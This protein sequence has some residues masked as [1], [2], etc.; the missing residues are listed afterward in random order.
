MGLGK[1]KEKLREYEKEQ[2]IFTSHTD[3]RA[4]EH[5]LP[6]ELIIGNL[7]NPENLIDFM[8][9]KARNLGE[10]KFK[11]IFRLSN[12]KFLIVVAVLNKSISIVTAF[13]RYR[14]WVRKP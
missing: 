4:I 10:S 6:A 9:Q 3:I 5:E 8:E 12:T 2:I 14:K 11:L 1:L 13:M 7:Q